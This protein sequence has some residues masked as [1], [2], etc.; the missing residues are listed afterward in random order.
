VQVPEGAF[1]GAAA[2][3]VRWGGLARIVI[4]AAIIGN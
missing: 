4:E 3:Q 1:M 2:V